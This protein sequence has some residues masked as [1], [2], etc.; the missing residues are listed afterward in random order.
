MRAKKSRLGQLP[1]RRTTTRR[2]LTTTDA[3]TL[4]KSKRHVAG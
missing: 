1:L 2:Q 3:A 4:I